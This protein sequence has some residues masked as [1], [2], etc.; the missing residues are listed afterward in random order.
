MTKTTKGSSSLVNDKK[1]RQKHIASPRQAVQQQHVDRHRE[2]FAKLNNMVQNGTDT[3][4][5]WAKP[6]QSQL[7][8]NKLKRIY[9]KLSYITG[10]R[11][12]KAPLTVQIQ[13]NG[14]PETLYDPQAS[15][16]HNRRHFSQA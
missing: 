13:V 11:V 10:K 1:M 7:T 9:N 4:K 6:N 2:E 16:V 5:R 12:D 14:H 3:A 15:Q 8:I